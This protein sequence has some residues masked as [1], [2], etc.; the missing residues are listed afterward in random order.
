MNKRGIFLLVLMILSTILVFAADSDNDGLD[1]S[2][3]TTGW[4]AEWYDCSNEKQRLDV[5]SSPTDSD[6]DD[7]SLND[8][9]ERLWDLNPNNP[10]TDNDSLQEGNQIYSFVDPCPKHCNDYC[11]PKSSQYQKNIACTYI[12]WKNTNVCISDYNNR[13]IFELINKIDNGDGTYTYVI[14][15]TNNNDCGLSYFSFRLPLGVNATSPTDS[16]IYNGISNN[17]NVENPTNNPFY[18]IKFETIGEGVKNGNSDI[19]NITVDKDLENEIIKFQAKGCL[20]VGNCTIDPMTEDYLFKI[21]RL[22]FVFNLA[23]KL[24]SN[25]LF[26]LYT[27][28]KY[29]D[30]DINFSDSWVNLTYD[31][32]NWSSGDAYLGYNESLITTSLDYTANNHS[33]DNKT[34]TYY[35]RKNFNITNKSSLEKI[36]FNID[37]DDGYVAYLNGYHLV[38]STGS[39]RDHYTYVPYHESS[40][41]DLPSQWNSYNLNAAD[42]S[43]LTNGENLIAVEIHQCTPNSSDIVLGAYLVN[44]ENISSKGLLNNLT[45]MCS[46]LNNTGTSEDKLK[47]ELMALWLNVVSADICYKQNINH[48]L[49]SGCENIPADTIEELISYAENAIINNQTSEYSTIASYLQMINEGKCLDCVV[50]EEKPPKPPKTDIKSGGLYCGDGQCTKAHNENC[51]NCPEDCGECPAIEPEKEAAVSPIK[52]EKPEKFIRIPLYLFA[53]LLSAAVIYVIAAILILK[54]KTILVVS[55]NGLFKSI[56]TKHILEKKLKQEKRNYEYKVKSTGI[57]AHPNLK[58]SEKLRAFA[59]NFNLDISKTKTKTLTQ[60]MLKNAALVITLDSKQ[61]DILSKTAPDISEDLKEKLINLDV[62]KTGKNTISSYKNIYKKLE[63]KIRNEDILKDIEELKK[64]EKS[65][66]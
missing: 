29:D 18:S 55:N 59:E 52:I 7:D 46:I 48:N 50:R 15:V 11:E 32:S 25:F 40:I 20:I 37:Y 6:S 54:R 10:D 27:N 42:K 24:K 64:N 43:R 60:K 51:E 16:S 56:I 12:T 4:T 57:F 34:I 14:N 35:F 38:N 61:K 58:P 9:E 33:K 28:W 23:D 30:N 45:D 36:E 62:K 26:G 47:K 49:D 8:F 21:Q 31:D 17:Y 22:S 1:D 2:N 5:N 63:E 66:R 3:E 65:K 53:A 39:S 44:Y 41:G 19:F 13:Y